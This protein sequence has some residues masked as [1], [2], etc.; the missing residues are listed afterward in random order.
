MSDCQ[1]CAFFENYKS[2]PNLLLV[3]TEA[4]HY[5]ILMK[6]RLGHILGEFFSNYLGNL[7][8]L[9]TNMPTRQAC[10]HWC[11]LTKFL[12]EKSPYICTVQNI[13][14]L[15]TNT[16]SNA[17]GGILSRDPKAPKIL[18]TR[19]YKCTNALCRYYAYLAAGALQN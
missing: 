1:L 16:L 10:C 14:L 11:N 8:T 7:V 9:P 12:L 15:L 4:L 2:S 17:H 19:Y 13:L 3:A 6:S 18:W 5:V